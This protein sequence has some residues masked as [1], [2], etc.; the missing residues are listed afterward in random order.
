VL[1]DRTVTD[2]HISEDERDLIVDKIAE[3]NR[4][5]SRRQAGEFLSSVFENYPAQIVSDED[6]TNFIRIRN[7]I[8]HSGVMSHRDLQGREYSDA[9]HAEHMRLK[10]LMERV[11]LAMLGQRPN[12]MK[13][14][15]EL[16]LMGR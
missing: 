4:P 7:E 3:L 15:W 8:T 16:W 2:G 11:F 10:S 9:V 12:L 14:S 1:L 5:A 13:F 6:L